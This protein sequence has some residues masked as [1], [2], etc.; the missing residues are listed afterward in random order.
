MELTADNQIEM[1]LH[2]GKCLDELPSNITPRDWSMVQVG[3][4]KQGIQIW[5]NRHNCNVMHMD[6]EGQTHPA[7]VDA[8]DD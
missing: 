4:T 5:C 6:F 8:G 2:C 1:Y 7:N 3:W